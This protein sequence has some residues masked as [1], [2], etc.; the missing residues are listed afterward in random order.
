[1]V[2]KGANKVRYLRHPGT[3]SDRRCIF[4]VMVYICCICV[5]LWSMF[6]NVPKLAISHFIWDSLENISLET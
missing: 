6:R 5:H 4:N 1:M 3:S 2:K